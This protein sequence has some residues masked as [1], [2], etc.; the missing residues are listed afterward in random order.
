[1]PAAASTALTLRQH[2]SACASNSAGPVPSGATPICPEICSQRALADVS[3]PWLNGPVGAKTV[4]GLW[5]F[6][7]ILLRYSFSRAERRLAQEIEVAAVI[8][9]QDLLAIEPGIAARR[10]GGDGRLPPRQ[11]RRVDQQVEP[12]LLHAE[13]GA[14]AAARFRHRGPPCRPTPAN[15]PPP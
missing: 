5:V 3:T 6:M 14:V 15:T 13:A 9:L 12:A 1:M 11:L 2:C 4:P 8:G 10:R 7:G